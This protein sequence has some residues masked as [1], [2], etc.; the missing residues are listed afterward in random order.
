MVSSLGFLLNDVVR[1]HTGGT[2][3]LSIPN[4]C[5][6]G[7]ADMVGVCTGSRAW[8]PLTPSWVPLPSPGQVK[9]TLDR[10]Y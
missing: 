8:H 10:G 5:R 7:K 4:G 6:H 2:S 1:R 9:D 3:T